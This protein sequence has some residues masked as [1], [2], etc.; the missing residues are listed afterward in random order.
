MKT[1]ADLKLWQRLEVAKQHLKPVQSDYRVVFEADLDSPSAVLVPDPNW[2][3]CA[4]QGGILPPVHVYHELEF[5]DEGAI[6]NGHILHETPP[7]GPLSEE[8]AIEYLIKKDI[9]KHVWSSSQGNSRRFLICKSN[10]LPHSREWR[11]SWK[12]KQENEYDFNVH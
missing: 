5:D 12:I 7:I 6:T 3:A 4:L 8:E 9:P 1:L 2:M 10:Q 11:N